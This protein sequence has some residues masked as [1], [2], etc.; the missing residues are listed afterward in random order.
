MAAE[1]QTPTES[2]PGAFPTDKD[3][4]AH[5]RGRQRAVASGAP[6]SWALRYWASSS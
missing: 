6:F 3:F 5:L 2:P 1:L 4:V